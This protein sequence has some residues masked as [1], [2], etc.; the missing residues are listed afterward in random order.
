MAG[1]TKRRLGRGVRRIGFVKQYGAVLDPLDQPGAESRSRYPENQIVL[2][3]GRSEI[4]L[5][6][7]ATRGI[8]HASDRKQRVHSTVANWVGAARIYELKPG[9][10][11]R[12]V[13][14][15]ERQ[16]L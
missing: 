3:S 8:A 4:G 1:D 11:D 15:N 14:R 5:S 16:A 12:T 7:G 6:Y 9:F 13:K 2:R 10:T